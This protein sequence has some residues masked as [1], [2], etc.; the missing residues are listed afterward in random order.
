MAFPGQVARPAS[1]KAAIA[2]LLA[3][4]F[5]LPF[6]SSAALRNALLALATACVL[7][8]VATDAVARPRLP[9]WRVLAPIA[10]YCAWCVASVSWSVDPAYSMAELRPGLLYPFIAFLVFH[11]V[12]TGTAEIDLWAWSLSAGLAA[13]GAAAAAQLVMTGGW[14]PGH[15]HGDAGFYAT[16]VLLAAPLL[17]WLSLR[18]GPA[19]RGR[20]GVLAATALLTLYAMSWND[21]RIAWVALAAMAALAVAL[22]WQSLPGRERTRILAVAAGALLVFAL[23]F[24]ASIEQRTARLAG[25]PHAAEAQLAHD[26][27][28][29][30]WDH[31]ARRHGDAPLLG[32]GYGRGILQYDF[33][34]FVTP[35]V[36]NSKHTHAHN[37]LLN[38]LLQ[39]GLAGLALFTW[40]VV[41]LVREVATGLAAGP[42]G[43][44]I[45]TLGLVLLAGFAIRNMTDDFL[46][47]HNA[48]LAWSLAGAVLGAL[49]TTS[50]RTPA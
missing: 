23:L 6:S 49:R 31:A 17:A 43:R 21:N 11:A 16:H 9:S 22:S 18:S 41:A 20:Q 32:H 33:R 46:V 39:G 25:T 36:D 35:G 15:W 28:P 19:A 3:F 50:A 2:L 30:I 24:V 26:P 4:L 1:A 38:V 8:G 7:Y 37:L 42:R 48:L 5:V 45:A 34:M 47:R 27:R 10:A 14:E 13:L 12:T 29:A 40:M 44:A